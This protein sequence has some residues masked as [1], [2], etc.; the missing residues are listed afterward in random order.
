MSRECTEERKS[1]GGGG[2][3]GDRSCYKVSR[4]RGST[5]CATSSVDLALYRLIILLFFQCGKPGHISRDCTEQGSGGGGYGGRSGGGGYGGGDRGY[6]GGGGYG[7]SRGGGGD[8]NC[9]K[10]QQVSLSCMICR[11]EAGH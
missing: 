1:G 3:G 11:S 6:G 4:K 2:G 5:G 8:R 10:C 9:Y 7:G